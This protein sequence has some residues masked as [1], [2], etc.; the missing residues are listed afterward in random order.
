MSDDIAG[1]ADAPYVE[2]VAA[3]TWEDGC[4]S[5]RCLGVPRVTG[6]G[7]SMIAAVLALASRPIA[8]NNDIS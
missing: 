8:Q 4:Y 5:A 1:L 7:E 3:L 2:V 6:T